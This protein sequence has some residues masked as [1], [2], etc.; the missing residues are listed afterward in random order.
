MVEVERNGGWGGVDRAERVMKEERCPVRT[1]IRYKITFIHLP[2]KYIHVS[3]Q[4]YLGDTAG[5]VSGH[6]I[7]RMSQ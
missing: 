4:A 5:S 2:K 7:K 6:A 1:N 3:R